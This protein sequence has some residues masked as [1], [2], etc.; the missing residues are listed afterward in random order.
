MN[1]SLIAPFWNLFFQGA[2]VTLLASMLAL[3]LGLVLGTGIGLLRQSR[4][5]ILQWFS[6]LWVFVLRGTPL[7]VQL[8]LIYFALPQA[9]INLPAFW[10]G[11]VG[12]GINSSAYVAEILRGGI[13]SVAKGQWEAAQVLGLSHRQ[14]LW[15]VILPQSLKSALPA[16]GN[17]F[18]SLI[19]ESSL[20]STLAITDLTQ[21]GN[22]VRSVTYASFES[23]IVV[24]A[25][26]L[27]LTTL[28]SSLTKMIEHRIT[29]REKT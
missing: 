13:L 22:Q 23:F 29:G 16:L 12:V 4:Y 2:R 3:L 26:Y 17:E 18:V 10:A 8:F 11:V 25:L 1:F 27:C 14:T 15:F 20:L 9:G 21:A 5:L 19:K 6:R 24:G 7:I 28:F